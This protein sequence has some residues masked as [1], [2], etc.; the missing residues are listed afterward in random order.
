MLFSPITARLRVFDVYLI[1]KDNR[2]GRT[3]WPAGGPDFKAGVLNAVG[4]KSNNQWEDI[5]E[6]KNDDVDVFG[7]AIAPR[8]ILTA[9]HEGYHAI[10]IM[11]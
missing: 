1:E 5:L 10:R 4:F 8:K 2:L 3:L 7:G 9:I 11:E 6:E